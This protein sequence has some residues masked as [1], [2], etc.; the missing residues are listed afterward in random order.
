[1]TAEPPGLF[2]ERGGGGPAALAL[3]W[4]LGSSGLT[5]VDG[6]LL[7]STLGSDGRCRRDVGVEGRLA[8]E[9]E[10]E[11]ELG[12]FGARECDGAGIASRVGMLWGADIDGALGCC[13]KRSSRR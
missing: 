11:G 9:G 10:G 2:I 1:M 7:E 13:A 6:M 4:D 8:L 12:E 5:G 3:L